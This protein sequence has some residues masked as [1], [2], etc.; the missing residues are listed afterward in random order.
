M[1]SKHLCG[2]ATDLAIA[3]IARAADRAAAAAADGVT[4][5]T[6][7][8]AVAAAAAVAAGVTGGGADNPFALQ[9][10]VACLATCCHYLCSWAQVRP[11]PTAAIPMGTMAYSCSACW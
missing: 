7:E 10:P 2:P 3:A 6:G 1:V 8:E 5:V 4:G 11:R 9:L